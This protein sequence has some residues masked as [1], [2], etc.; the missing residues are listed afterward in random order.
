MSTNKTTTRADGRDLFLSRVIDAPCEVVYRAWTE[1]AL[2]E[3]WFVP[4]PWTVEVVKSDVRPGGESLFVMRGPE[5]QEFPNPGIYLEVVPNKKLVFTDAFTSA[6]QPSDKP[7]MVAEVTF[8]D[9]GGKTR[10][11]AHV[12]HW[13]VEDREAHEKMGFHEGWAQVTEQLAGLVEKS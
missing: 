2:L 5:G 10:Y 7:F 6:W 13:S 1:P 8:T 11:E 9:E 3:Q 4:R 12:R